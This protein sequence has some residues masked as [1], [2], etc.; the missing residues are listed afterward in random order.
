MSTG[1]VSSRICWSPGRH[2]ARVNPDIDD[3]VEASTAYEPGRR[4]STVDDFLEMLEYVE[5]AFTEKDS[6]G[7]GADAGAGGGGGPGSK[8]DEDRGEPEKDP[9]EAVTGDVLARRWEVV[10]RLGTGSTSRAFLVRDLAGE[11]RRSGTL[12]VAVLKVALCEAKHAV[13]DR[14]AQVLGRIHRDSSIIALYEQEPIT[15]AGRRVLALEYVGDSRESKD[16]DRGDGKGPRRR[17]DTVAR[18]LRDNGRLGMTATA[19]PVSRAPAT[20]H[21]TR[22]S[23][24]WSGLFG[25]AVSCRHVLNRGSGSRAGGASGNRGARCSRRRHPR[26]RTPRGRRPSVRVPGRPAPGCPWVCRAGL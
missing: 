1:S 24:N 22:T 16:Q 14:E 2:Q 26:G 23:P 17:E 19:P 6:V 12:P 20:T 7:T 15:L 25:G 18:Q 10:R 3:L 4:L 8:T 21:W 13:L 5:Q 11:P 9:L